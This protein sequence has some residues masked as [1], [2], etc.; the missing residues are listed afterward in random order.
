MGVS[1][2]VGGPSA[3]PREEKSLFGAYCAE[4]HGLKTTPLAPPLTGVAERLTREQIVNTIR[5]GTGRMP[6]FAA[7]L[8]DSAI[9]ELAEYVRS[10][11]KPGAASG[12]ARSLSRTPERPA[13]PR[14]G[15]GLSRD[16]GKRF[17]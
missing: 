10:G 3:A 16:R 6:A 4:W 8:N 14:D 2:G 9:A 12:T 11:A 7:A 13:A 15:Q 1:T 5:G 17:S